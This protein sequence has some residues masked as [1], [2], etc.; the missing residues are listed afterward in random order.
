M[1]LYQNQ[2]RNLGGKKILQEV[3]Q[4]LHYIVRPHLARHPHWV[5]YQNPEPFVQLVLI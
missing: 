1:S 3:P 5:G 2:M 4:H